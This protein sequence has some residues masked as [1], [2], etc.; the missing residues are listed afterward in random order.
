MAA[1]TSV[2]AEADPPAF[3]R[4]LDGVSAG[5][6]GLR[7][8]TSQ[9][10]RLERGQRVL[11]VGC[12]TGE[13]TRDAA[14]LV[15]TQGT[16]LGVD[17]SATMVAEARSRT[18]AG[19]AMFTVADAHVLP[20][21]DAS[22]DACRVERTLQHLVEPAR[23]AREMVRVVRPGGRVVALEPDWDAMI[24]D[25]DDT[26][27]TTQI[28]RTVASGIAHPRI[29][30][31]LLGMFVGLGLEDVEASCI[32]VRSGYVWF[33]NN[34]RVRDAIDADRLR[35]WLADGQRADREG[36]F[37]AVTPVFVV[38]GRR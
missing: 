30:R 5:V 17:A 18:A 13:T 7:E 23:A 29:G 28:V 14:L 27:L 1:W 15:G 32:G 34:R 2:D 36:R 31:R 37:L 16:A 24:V 6:R 12:G 33:G 8:V 35:T 4:C 3:I 19:R 10:L 38:S 26:E 20:L 22:F 25:H 11:D 9:R 21:A